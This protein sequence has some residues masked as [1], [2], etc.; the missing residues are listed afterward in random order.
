MYGCKEDSGGCSNDGV[1]EILFVKSKS[2]CRKG[3]GALNLAENGVENGDS[4]EEL[5]VVRKKEEER[6]REGGR[7]GVDC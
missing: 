6:K 4:V 3:N 2:N 5:E 7:R 1:C